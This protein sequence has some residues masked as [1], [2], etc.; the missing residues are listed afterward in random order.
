MEKMF[1]HS[2]YLIFMKPKEINVCLLSYMMSLF[3]HSTWKFMILLQIYIVFFSNLDY[4]SQTVLSYFFYSNVRGV[5]FLSSFQKYE[6]FPL[7]FIF[8]FSKY[9][10]YPCKLSLWFM[11]LIF[12]DAIANLNLVLLLVS[13]LLFPYHSHIIFNLIFSFQL[14]IFI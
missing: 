9:M 8:S 13:F 4:F 10:Q 2:N 11:Y 5:T 1:A 7:P 6:P 3:I 12:L 14:V